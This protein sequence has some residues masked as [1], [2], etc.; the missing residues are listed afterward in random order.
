MT[1]SPRSSLNQSYNQVR[2]MQ[3]C[4]K[5]PDILTFLVSEDNSVNS[6]INFC[7]PVSF[8][9]VANCIALIVPRPFH[10]VALMHDTMLK[11]V[12]VA[13]IPAAAVATSLYVIILYLK[14]FMV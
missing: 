11:E 10:N 7:S 9:M 3:G 8:V 2:T 13:L 12:P 5:L 4:K 14:L 1:K 6:N